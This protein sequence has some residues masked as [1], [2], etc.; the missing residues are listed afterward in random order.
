MPLR[1]LSKILLIVGGLFTMARSGSAAELAKVILLGTGTPIPDPSSSGP[2][3]AVV[4]NGQAYLF[5]AGPGVVRRAQAAAEKFRM[6]ALDATNLTRLFFTLLHSDHTLGYPDL[7]FH[8]PM[9]AAFL[10]E[11]AARLH[12][13]MAPKK[14]GYR[15]VQPLFEGSEFSVNANETDAGLELWT[16]N[17]EGQPTVKAT[18]TW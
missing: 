15:G 9:Q 3:V 13:G 5:D 16:A 7:I 6:A 17:S 2:C 14:F 1:K 4:V 8:G 10:A 11:M 12:G 18:A